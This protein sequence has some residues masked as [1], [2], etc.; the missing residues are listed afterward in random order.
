M[1][2]LADLTKVFDVSRNTIKNWI[3]EFSDYM[4]DYANPAEAGTTRQF[5]NEDAAVLSLV[6]SMRDDNQSYEAIGAALADGER[7]TWPPVGAEDEETKN[8][9][10]Q[11]VTQL[12]ARASSLEGQLAAID[13]ERERE[14]AAAAV[15]RDRLLSE[16]ETV[17]AEALDA[18]KRAAA[19][20][21]EARI[22]KELATA[23]PDTRGFWARL[24]GKG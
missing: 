2:G 24:T 5:T 19:A 16:L 23:V 17:R 6:A 3:L 4:S 14:R 10:T 13:Q 21:A 9:T 11:L 22:L 15:E 8:D 1:L 7:G 12:V 18:E 20:E